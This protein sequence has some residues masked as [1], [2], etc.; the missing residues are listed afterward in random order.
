MLPQAKAALCASPTSVT[1]IKSPHAQHT[2]P[3]SPLPIPTGA[4]APGQPVA[5][6]ESRPPALH[7]AGRAPGHLRPDVIVTSRE[8]KASTTGALVAAQLALPA[9]VADGLHEQQREQVGWLSN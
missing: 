8:R 7:S 2:H 5:A 9:I 1:I 3:H 4:Q 6:H